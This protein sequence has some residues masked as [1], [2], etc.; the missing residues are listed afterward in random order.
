MQYS[1]RWDGL[2]ESADALKQVEREQAALEDLLEQI[3]TG[4]DR[5]G[6][7]HEIS[8]SLRR[9]REDT[10]LQK[11]QMIQMEQAARRIGA[12]YRSTE[13]AVYNLP[14]RF[15]GL[16]RKTPS[17]VTSAGTVSAAVA[18]G[19]SVA[20]ASLLLGMTFLTAVVDR[21]RSYT[22]FGAMVQRQ[23]LVLRLDK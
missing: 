7:L 1:I 18:A 3:Q 11:R 23:G 17:T 15:N 4:L 12:L 6:A 2:E 9:C 19:V 14:E 22:E 13:T 8:R 16:E 20:A 21:S 5:I 10:A